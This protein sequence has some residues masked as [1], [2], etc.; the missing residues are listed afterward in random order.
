[1]HRLY[2]QETYT[3]SALLW[4]SDQRRNPS[5][6]ATLNYLFAGVVGGNVN[7]IDA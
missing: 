5:T 4:G 3:S 6:M 7:W 1:M 2:I